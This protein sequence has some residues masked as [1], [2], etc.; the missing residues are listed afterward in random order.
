AGSIR[1]KPPGSV[2]NSSTTVALSFQERGRAGGRSVETQADLAYSLNAPSGGGRRQEM[3]VATSMAVRRL[4]P[5]ECERL[6]GF[7]D[8]YT[9]IPYG[10]PSKKKLEEDYIKYLMRGGKLTREECYG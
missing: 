7:P 3:N 1:T 9:F 5:R 2:E 6:Q 8:D 4:T 10:R